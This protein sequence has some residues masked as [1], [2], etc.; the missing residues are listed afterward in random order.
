M[1][2]ILAAIEYNS[3][4]NTQIPTF[5]LNPDVHPIADETAAIRMALDIIDPMGL[6]QSN[7]NV[8]RILVQV[9]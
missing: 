6:I 1:Y 2:R 4:G 7:R 5:Y 9:S 8:K 3:G